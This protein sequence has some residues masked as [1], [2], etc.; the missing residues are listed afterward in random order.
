MEACNDYIPYFGVGKMEGG[1]EKQT[2]ARTN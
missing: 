2:E 1:V